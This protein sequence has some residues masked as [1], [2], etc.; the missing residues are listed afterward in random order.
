MSLDLTSVAALKSLPKRHEFF[1]GIDSDGCVFDSM[2]LKHQECFC[3]AFIKHFGLQPASK[4]AREVWDFVNLYSRHRGCNRF[5][6][7]QV[8]HQLMCEWDVFSARGLKISTL[9]SLAAWLKEETRLGNPALEARVKATNDVELARVLA[10]S[11]EVNQRVADMVS[12]VPPLP[13]VRESLE[14]IRARAD[15][16]VV[17][18]TPTEALEREWHEHKLDRLV[19]FIAGQEAGTKS[20]HILYATRGRYDAEKILKIGDAPGDLKAAKANHALFYPIIPGREEQSWRR[21]FDEGSERFF[22]GT[23]AGDYQQELLEEFNAALPEKA[24]W[25]GQSVSSGTEMYSGQTTGTISG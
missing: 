24:P 10:W 17:S 1:V 22:N 7:I 20:E 15:V 11:R 25:Q 21:F 16:I 6:A 13:L 3:P 12:D 8:A 9:P 4:H 2:C 19:N 5:V 14:K 23:F 18:Q